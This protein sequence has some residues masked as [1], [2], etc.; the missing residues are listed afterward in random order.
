M[1]LRF[2]GFI[3]LGVLSG[4]SQL[5]SDLSDHVVIFVEGVLRFSKTA[6]HFLYG[7]VS[8]RTFSLDGWVKELKN[9]EVRRAIIVSDAL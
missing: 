8:E 9:R 5:I 7:G 2:L 6:G 4:H 3:W 1:S